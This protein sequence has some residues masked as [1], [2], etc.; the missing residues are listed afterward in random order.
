MPVSAPA[1][2]A[3]TGELLAIPIPVSGTSAGQ[4]FLAPMFGVLAIVV[5]VLVLRWSHQPPKHARSAAIG[6]HGLLVPVVSVPQVQRAQQ[7]AQ[8]LSEIGIRATVSPAKGE[9]LVLVWPWQAQ[10]AR[11]RLAQHRDR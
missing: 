1:L 10:A 5:L 11:D 9:H 2:T 3:A 4:Y 7:L 6:D 8:Q